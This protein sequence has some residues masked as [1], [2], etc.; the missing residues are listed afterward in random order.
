MSWFSQIEVGVFPS[1]ITDTAVA[2]PRITVLAET[3]F[4]RREGVIKLDQA[5]ITAEG[6]CAT[7]AEATEVILDDLRYPIPQS[8]KFETRGWCPTWFKESERLHKDT[9]KM[10]RGWFRRG[11]ASSGL[12]TLMYL[13]LDNDRKDE[14]HVSISKL[15]RIL[16]EIGVP[17]ALYTSYSHR[18][19][20]HKV[21]AAMPISRY[22]TYD[23][24]HAMYEV[25]N[26]ALDGQLDGSIYDPG[27]YLYGPPF[28]GIRIDNSFPDREIA[29]NVGAVLALDLDA[30][31]ALDVD[32]VLAFRADQA[33][34]PV[35]AEFFPGRKTPSRAAPRPLT[36]DEI[37]E[38]QRLI[39]TTQ[40]TGGV[41][42]GNPSVFN[43][44][45]TEDI[46][47]RSL[48]HHQTMMSLLTK[49]WVKSGGSLT[50]GDLQVLQ[51][52]IDLRWGNYCHRKYG[53]GTLRD[54]ITSIMRL[55]VEPR[56]DTRGDL[57]AR[58]I[59]RLKRKTNF[60]Q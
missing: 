35:T 20:H 30:A 11:D 47:R 49:C 43:P 26:W 28:A 25:F 44:A 32:A 48:G 36:P 60:K 42:I 38:R 27:D 2:E 16:K 13:D 51:T 23:E 8:N 12:I 6:T 53:G 4:D 45:W 29:L 55:P 41:S 10:E 24:A 14:P 33:T 57:I 59:A 34:D 39:A 52:E 37:I 46:E 18:P 5:R 31:L 56:T 54:D 1:L 9:W 15:E 17:H 19:E 3:Y 21:R 7:F 58:Q 50:S 40:V 22:A